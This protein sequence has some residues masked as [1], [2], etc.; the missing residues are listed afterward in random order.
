MGNALQ[1]K[2]SL[3]DAIDAFKKAIVLNPNNWHTYI[4]M[5]NALQEQGMYNQSIKNYALRDT[6]T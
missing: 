2:G 1:S 5:G 4:N 6:H 3:V